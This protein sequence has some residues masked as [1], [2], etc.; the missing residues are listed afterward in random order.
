MST[1]TKYLGYTNGVQRLSWTGPSATITAHLWGGGGGRGGSDS[2][3]GGNG[4][5]GGY[6]TTNFTIT[7]GD[8]LDVAVGGGGGNGQSGRGSALGGTAGAS[9]SSGGLVFNTRTTPA[10][11]AVYPY[12]NSSYCSFLNTYGVWEAAPGYTYFNRNYTVN[13]PSTGT[14]TF[15]FSVD[16]YGSVTLDGATIISLSSSSAAN[17]QRSYQTTV[18]VTAGNH[19]LSINAVNTGGPGSVALLVAGGTVF[20]G[21]AGGNAGPA[22]SS[23]AGG[24]GGGA[25]VLLLNS[26]V[27]AVAGGGAGGGGGGNYGSGQ[28]APGSVGQATVGTYAGQNGRDH[29]RDGGGGGGG[30]GGWAAGQGGN[31]PGSD[32]GGY[33]GSYGLGTAV[34]ENPTGSSAANSSSPYYRSGEARGATASAG[35]TPGVAVIVI[36]T[37]GVNVHDGAQ[38][39]PVDQTYIKDNEVWKPVRTIWIKSGS[40]WVPVIGGQPPAFTTVDGLIGVNSRPW[41]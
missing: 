10:V 12:T 4:S 5:G 26:S 23:G 25:T 34:S 31:I 36:Q 27:V 39:V 30:G 9:Y 18:N 13:F 29:P 1:V 16:N 17:F 14:Y 20:S 2:Y 8:V 22:G 7:D 41:S 24:G 21:G 11:P 15:T 28:S 35:S 38:F 19:T 33:A 40:N 3:Q 6:S 37:T 32:V